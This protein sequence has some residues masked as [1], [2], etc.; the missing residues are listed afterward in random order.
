MSV[1][2]FGRAA[3]GLLIRN[4]LSFLLLPCLKGRQYGIVFGKLKVKLH[5]V[6]EMGEWSSGD[7]WHRA[8]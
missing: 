5:V 6:A 2:R 7:H 1:R 4:F 8:G 3:V